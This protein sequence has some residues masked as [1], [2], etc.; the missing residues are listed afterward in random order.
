MDRD[1]MAV[2]NTYT[3][4]FSFGTGIIAAGT[5][6]FLN[7]EMDD[8]SAKPARPTPMVCWAARPALWR[9]PNGRSAR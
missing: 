9:P 8:F 7:N 6:V 5:G 4:N 3:L 2:S 1:G